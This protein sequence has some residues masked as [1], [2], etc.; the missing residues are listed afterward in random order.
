MRRSVFRGFMLDN[1]ALLLITALSVILRLASALYQ[2]D[3]ISP[4]P[5][6]HDQVSYHALACRVLAGHGFTFETGWWPLTR[7]GSPTAH[8]SYLYTIYLAAIYFLFGPHPLVARLIQA[9]LAGVLHPWLCWRIGSRLFGNQ[10]GLIAA[11]LSAVYAYFVFYAGSLMTETFFILS[12]LWVLDRALLLGEI[13]VG[14][15]E[16]VS[17]WALLGLGI[18]LA[19]LLRQTFLLLLPVIFAWLFWR[20][21][22][23]PPREPVRGLAIASLLAA[24]MILPWTIRNYHAFGRVVLLNTNAGFAMFWANHPIHGTDFVAI[25]PEEGPSYAQLVPPPLRSLDEAALD[26]ALLGEGLRFVTRDPGRYLWLSLSRV[27]EYFKFWPSSSSGAISNIARAGSF[28]LLLPF[29]V[30]G[31][32]VAPGRSRAEDGRQEPAELGVS[33]GRLSG[34]VLLYLVTGVYTLMHLL[35]WSLI[36]YRLPVDAVLMVFAAAGALFLGRIAS[37]CVSIW[38]NCCVG[39][40]THDVR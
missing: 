5:G 32:A 15:E 29:M 35:S 13:G 38:R 19:A 8:W 40:D 4:L 14:A 1:Q 17:S 28:G 31:L 25:L 16:S 27:K 2:G 26:R 22:A 39:S 6:V 10:A 21:R 24:A 12:V 23:R 20:L 7:A 9:L 37:P 18:G 30:L 36:R 33:G 11:L 34:V 3:V